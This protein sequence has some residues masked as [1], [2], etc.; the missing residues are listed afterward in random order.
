[1]EE[2]SREVEVRSSRLSIHRRPIALRAVSI[3]AL[4]YLVHFLEVFEASRR[5]LQVRNSSPRAF[6]NLYRFDRVHPPHNS[7]LTSQ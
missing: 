7:F 6:P 1:M 5:K 4:D 2:R 3:L